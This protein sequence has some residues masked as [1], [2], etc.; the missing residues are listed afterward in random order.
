MRALLLEPPLSV[1]NLPVHLK[2]QRIYSLGS[3]DDMGSWKNGLPLRDS[4]PQPPQ[5][6]RRTLLCVGTPIV[7]LE[8]EKAPDRNVSFSL[9][10]TTPPQQ[11]ATAAVAGTGRAPLGGNHL[12]HLLYPMLT[13]ATLKGFSG[14]F[15]IL[16]TL[17]EKNSGPERLRNLHKVTQLG[18]RRAGIP[19][20]QPDPR[21]HVPGHSACLRE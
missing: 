4:A 18:N 2:G 7:H 6:P 11:G 13:Y 8:P 14:V 10:P 3:Q 1:I 21:A 17:R 15:V 19:S 16:S 5:L 20:R 12:C 9:T